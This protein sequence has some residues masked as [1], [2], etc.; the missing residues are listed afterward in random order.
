MRLA[1]PAIVV[2]NEELLDNHQVELA[3]VLAKQ[4]YVVH[5]Q[6]N[7][8]P[9]ALD[10]LEELREGINTWPPVNSGEHRKSNTIKQVLDEEMGY[11]D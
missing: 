5:G 10:R 4:G 11:L 6:V 1:I 8:I 9:T 3:E 7:N 2:P